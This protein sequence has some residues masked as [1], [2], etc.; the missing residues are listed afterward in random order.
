MILMVSQHIP[1]SQNPNGGVVTVMI[2]VG[3]LSPADSNH[4]EYNDDDDD[5]KEKKNNWKQCI[6]L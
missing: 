5:D 4:I 2:T 3:D 1:T 6:S